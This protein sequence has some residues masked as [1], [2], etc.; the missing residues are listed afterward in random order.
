MNLEDTITFTVT[1]ADDFGDDV[2]S[3]EY[4]TDCAVEQASAFARG[5]NTELQTGEIVA[6][7]DPA[8][9][10]WTDKGL[11]MS[12]MTAD[13]KGTQYRVAGVRPGGSLITGAEDLIELTLTKSENAYVE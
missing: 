2:A 1:T 3:T 10:V 8:S 4:E 11:S 6:W 7:I 13:Y 9:D 5:I 12:G